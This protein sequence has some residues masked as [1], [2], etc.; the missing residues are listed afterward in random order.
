LGVLLAGISDAGTPA[1]AA[2][3]FDGL[4]AARPEF[5]RL[6]WAE[7]GTQGALL[8]EVEALQDAGD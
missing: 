4:A 3:A 8:P 1:S 6:S 7:L 2:D 5:G